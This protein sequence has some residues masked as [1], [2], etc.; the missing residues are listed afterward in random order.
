MN[1]RELA[2][3]EAV[4]GGGEGMRAPDMMVPLSVTKMLRAMA[5]ATKPAPR[6]PATTESAATAGR[7]RGGDLR[8]GQDVLD[9]GVGGHE[10]DADDEEAADERDG[11]SA[12]GTADFA[13]D[14][15]EI[16]PSVVGPEGGDEREHESAEAAV[17]ARGETVAKF[18]SE[19]D[20]EAKQMPATMRMSRALR[21]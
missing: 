14:H 13:G 5:A 2:E 10:E 19:P 6:G 7:S 16:V 9:G 1:V 3:E 11:K 8:G 20:A 17:C 12:L 21:R 4:A 15:G 18:A